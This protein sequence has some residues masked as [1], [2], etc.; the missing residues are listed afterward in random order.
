[1]GSNPVWRALGQPASRSTVGCKPGHDSPWTLLRVPTQSGGPQATTSP[2]TVGCKPGHDRS[3]TN[4]VP[5][6]TG[7]T[8][9]ETSVR[10]SVT[11]NPQGWET[12]FGRYT[13]EVSRSSAVDAG[14]TFWAYGSTQWYCR[15]IGYA[16]GSLR[17]SVSSSFLLSW[18]PS[19]SCWT[20]WSTLR[21]LL[22]LPGPWGRR[23][24]AH[25]VSSRMRGTRCSLSVRR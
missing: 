19:R 23:L 16:V 20:K 8:S 11:F 14:D 9:A 3:Q 4:S 21:A 15:T 5:A 24:G 1:M 2:S 25:R 13:R 22:R 7:K 6:S 12:V 17:L 10:R 18:L